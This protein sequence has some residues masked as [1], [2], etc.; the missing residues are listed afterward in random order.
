VKLLTVCGSLRAGSSNAALL[1][2]LTL[3]APA[4]FEISSYNGLEDIPAFNPDVE[5]DESRIPAAVTEWRGAVANADAVVISS[6]EYAHGIPGAL[7]NALDWLV[8]SLQFVD[9]PVGLLNASSASRYAHPQLVEVL[10]VMNAKLVSG[11][12]IVIDIPRRGATAAQLVEDE[13]VAAA[14]RAVVAAL[15]TS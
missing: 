15:T 4:G 6:P 10:T 7:K 12:S 14:L 9:K 13:N 8:G 1:A 2:A 5:E 3:V 11:A